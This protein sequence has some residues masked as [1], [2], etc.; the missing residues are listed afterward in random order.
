MIH[1][2]CKNQHYHL[3]SFHKIFVKSE[4]F[5][6]VVVVAL[7]DWDR[8]HALVIQLGYDT[9]IRLLLQDADMGR[10]NDIRAVTAHQTVL[11]DY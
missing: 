3:I 6:E 2:L 8:L 4:D 5:G 10:I 11:F 1:Q 9:A 7:G